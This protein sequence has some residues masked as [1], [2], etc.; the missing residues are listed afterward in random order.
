MRATITFKGLRWAM[1]DTCH[2]EIEKAV[3]RSAETGEVLYV[4]I[5]AKAIAALC[6]ASPKA[7][8]DQLTE[9]GIRAKVTMQFGVPE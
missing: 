6:G 8:A 3:R 7:I 4:A 9:A 5:V 1:S 2:A